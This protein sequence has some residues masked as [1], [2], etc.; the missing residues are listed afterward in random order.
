MRCISFGLVLVWKYGSFV[1]LSFVS[2]VFIS[3]IVDDVWNIMWLCEVG[4][5]YSVFYIV[6]IIGCWYII[7]LCLLNVLLVIGLL[8]LV[9]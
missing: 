1:M 8:C 7:R 9:R 2:V 4:L 5:L 6:G 3:I